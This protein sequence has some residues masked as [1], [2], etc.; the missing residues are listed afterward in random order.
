MT[1]FAARFT[2]WTRFSGGNFNFQIRD[3][4]L[5]VFFGRLP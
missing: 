1:G 2:T 4:L 3:V 5:F